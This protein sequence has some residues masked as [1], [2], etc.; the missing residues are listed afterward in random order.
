MRITIAEGQS[1]RLFVV[2]NYTPQTSLEEILQ[3]AHCD[4]RT[5]DQVWVDDHQVDIHDSIEDV[6]LLEGSRISPQSPESLPD[7]EWV[8]L[9]AGGMAAG[10]VLPLHNKAALRIGRSPEATICLDSPSVSW[11][12]CVLNIEGNKVR[13]RDA[14]SSNGTFI[15]GEKIVDEDGVLV[16]EFAT[17][18][19]GG[20]TLL[21]QRG[22]GESAAPRPGVDTKATPARTVP[23]NRPPRLAG[24]PQPES[25]EIPVKKEAPK[26]AKFSWIAV[27]APLVMAVMM[28]MVMGSLRF[29]MIALLSPVMAIGS[30]W[31]QKRRA[32]KSE[33]E[34]EEKFAKA[35][36]DFSLEI[37]QAA[38]V[39]RAVLRSRVPDTVTSYVRAELPSTRLWQ[40]RADAADYLSLYVGDGNAPFTVP[41][42]GSATQGRKRKEVQELLDGAVIPAAPIEVSLASGPIGIWGQ[43]EDCLALTRSLLCQLATHVGPAD[44]NIGIFTDHAR[45]F[46]WL[47]TAWL[48]HLRQ[49]GANPDHI[50]LGTSS[51]SSQTLLRSLRDNVDGL[52]VGTFVM[53][54]DGHTL[55]E[56]RDCPARDLLSRK[57][58]EKS[59]PERQR[60]TQV[61]G[62]VIAASPDQ[63]PSACKTVIHVQHD[64]SLS[65][66]Y[67]ATGETIAHV[68]A[69][70]ISMDYAKDWARK[71]A[72]FDDP[73]TKN[74]GATLPSLTHLLPLLGLSELDSDKILESWSTHNDFTTPIGVSEDGVY[75]L[76]LVRDGPH[77]LVGGTTGSGKSEFLRSLV[78]GLAARV[79][80]EHLTFIL[81]DFKGGAAFASCD[82][83][84]HTIGT[85]SNLDA[86]L[87]DRALRALEAEMIYRQEKFAQA[88][89]GID[90][91]D[92]YLAT[93]PAEPM[94]RLL[95]VVDEFKQLAK[96]YPEVL[97]SLVS[98]AAVGRTLG[99]HMI[100]ATQ[101][102][103]GVVND[104]ILAN[105]NMRVALRVQ[106]REDSANVIDV[107]HAAAIGRDQRGRAYVKLGADDISPI[108]TALV[109]GRSDDSS[110]SS[111]NVIE[112][113]LG[114]PIPEATFKAA[115]KGEDNDL[116]RLISAICEA[117]E[118]AGY[119]PPRPVWP[120]PLG[121]RVDLE[122]G[123]DLP[124]RSQQKVAPQNPTMLQ[125]AL[126]D[127]PDG[128]RQYPAGWDWK[129]GNLLL[130][131]IPGSGTT[132]TLMSIAFAAAA[133]YTPDD[134]DVL[135]L[136]LGSRGLEALKDL[137]HTRAYVS[138]G[139]A[140][141][142]LQER[143][144]RFLHAELGK[145]MSSPGEYKPMLVLLDG[146][147]TL[148]DEFKDYEAL[149]L[150]ETFYQVWEKGPDVGIHCVATST[151][152]K[153]IP[154]QIDEVTTQKWLFRLAET[155]DYSLAGVDRAEIPPPVP[156]RC[157]IAESHHQ[158]HVA[159]SPLSIEETVR[160][161]RHRYGE[162]HA[163]TAAI[164][165][166]PTK[167]D[168]LEIP[169]QS[170][171]CGEPWRIP[172][173]LKDADLA[174]AYLEVYEGEHIL[175]AGPPRSGKSSTLL[176]IAQR[177]R[178][179]AT[180]QGLSINLWGIGGRRSPLHDAGL[181]QVAL[182][183]EAAGILAQARVSAEPTVLFIDDAEQIDDADQAISNLLAIP[184][185][186][187][188][189]IAAGRS[190]DL[191]SMY[192]H[193]TKKV[194]KGR[195]GLLLV[196][197][198]DYDGELLG[199][200]L[201]R[202]GSVKMSIAR[203]YL[204]TAGKPELIQAA[205]LEKSE[206]AQ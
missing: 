187:L 140:S 62:F 28:V 49:P 175:I 109:T 203:G 156:G 124:V 56:G 93:N 19:V 144:L 17:L 131:G 41:L 182:Y 116:D 25:L 178:H 197:N 159:I 168:P 38:Q 113:E 18:S 108:Q 138:G 24:P 52:P 166:L 104:D 39:E 10:K 205:T 82:Q 47:W 69:S 177:L 147:A 35:I 66:S 27:L 101:R 2:R 158:T 189:I 153:S 193:W 174:P 169:M 4:L 181:D 191:R 188:L 65:V 46:D 157:V 51:E 146:L 23:F 26:A 72:R 115:K 165:S 107:P 40:R 21:L 134:C 150:L 151:R 32:A 119:A 199:V 43:R 173:G 149:N 162:A 81:I 192:N 130:F 102:P 86:Q 121:E 114:R 125:I 179:D 148:R 103:A 44:L 118:R 15:N 87:A 61:S 155:Y 96:E 164:A 12:H 94:P 105:T 50:W 33:K 117:N 83:L 73:E 45:S 79:D 172:V 106:S 184:Q 70:G 185:S 97:S 180:Q 176:A 9:I 137:P 5:W 14:Q 42:E 55:L 1:S 112:V 167:L 30:W 122:F 100:L 135:I 190:D 91:L 85:V 99:V 204:C 7:S 3:E 31:E 154:S 92:A 170:Q 71:L 95:L 129:E 195:A 160:H 68:T 22:Y 29:A 161:F 141:R 67:P 196:P 53:L 186:Q 90:N 120:E 200:T 139:T 142:E 54:V 20:A 58:E 133:N 84:P 171:L 60:A 98:V 110:A 111:L 88:G 128:Q 152:L 76:D 75:S 11:S 34:E 37:A 89:D 127:D 57:I 63:L 77:G 80:P 16:D 206:E 202:R 64:A 194:G 143:L 74:L 145:R 201:P 183:T 36:E 198:V 8:V 6:V 126:S 123:T 78:A 163:K 13:V 59:S 132:T 136:D 48:P